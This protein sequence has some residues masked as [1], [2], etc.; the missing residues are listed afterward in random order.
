L[1][2]IYSKKKKTILGFLEN[3]FSRKKWLLGFRLNF[4]GGKK[5][6]GLHGEHNKGGRGLALNW[7]KNNTLLLTS[8]SLGPQK[9]VYFGH[10]EPGEILV[11][12]ADQGAQLAPRNFC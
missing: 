2:L 7:L 5:P 6:L 1:E 9:R 3:Y 10:R 12:L 4:P 8:V 11:N